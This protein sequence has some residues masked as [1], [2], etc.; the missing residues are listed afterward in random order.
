MNK[1]IKETS[2]QNYHGKWKW[3]WKW[4]H[5]ENLLSKARLHSAHDVL[6]FL[7]FNP[8]AANLCE[9]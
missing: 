4:F 3:K 6:F 9:I 8:L 2:K 7:M 1:R 5:R